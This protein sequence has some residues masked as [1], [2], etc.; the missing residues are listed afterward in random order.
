MFTI[1]DGTQG[2][3]LAVE[4]SGGYTKSDFEAFRKAF[5]E[6]LAPGHTPINILVKIDG[7][8]LTESE[9]GAFVEDLRYGLRH[10]KELGHIAVVG[11]SEVQKLLT[12]LDNLLF[13]DPLLG[14]TEKYFDVSEMDAAWSFVRS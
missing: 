1:L 13:G 5:E 9:F 6:A 8:S 2:T 11:H 7:M 3:V 12:G 14:F 4:I 10:R